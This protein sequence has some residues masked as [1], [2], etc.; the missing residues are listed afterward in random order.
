MSASPTPSVGDHVSWKTPQGRT[1]GRVVDKR[2]SDFTFDGQ[3]FR[4][5]DDNPAFIV[6]SDKSGK[7]AAHKASALNVLKG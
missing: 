4:A 7:Q 1:R 3:Q 6:E 2:T 5:S